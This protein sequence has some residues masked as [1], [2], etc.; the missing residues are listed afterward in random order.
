MFAPEHR[1][2][3]HHERR[4]AGKAESGDADAGQ[5]D[6]MKEGQPVDRQ[7]YTAQHQAG[8]VTACQL[9]DQRQA[10]QLREEHQR[11]HSKQRSAKHDCV[12]CG[13]GKLAEHPGQAEQQGGNVHEKQGAIVC[14]VGHGGLKHG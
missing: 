11:N 1:L 4:E 3:Q 7:K 13:A 6:G 9:A 2:Q 12:R 5:L 14:Q 10:A 8:Q